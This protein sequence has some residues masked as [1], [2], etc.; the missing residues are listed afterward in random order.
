MADRTGLR[1]RGGHCGALRSSGDRPGSVLL[2]RCRRGDPGGSGRRRS[3]RRGG[4]DRR[5]GGCECGI[6]LRG[7]GE[8]AEEDARPREHGSEGDDLEQGEVDVTGD[9]DPGAGE[10]DDE[11]GDRRQ[12]QPT[13]HAVHHDRAHQQQGGEAE[14]HARSDPVVHESVGVE[15]DATDEGEV[16][17]DRGEADAGGAGGSAADTGAPEA[18][19]FTRGGAAEDHDGA[20]AHDERAVEEGGRAVLERAELAEVQ[21]PPLRVGRGGDGDADADDQDEQHQDREAH[22]AGAEETCRPRPHASA[23]RRCLTESDHGR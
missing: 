12:E 11:D 2:G 6:P 3:D 18:A 5:G 14:H 1:P 10:E 8:G 4:D 19:Q 23:L 17:A 22:G 9:E 21:T 16:H 20:S 13:R 7:H 15:R